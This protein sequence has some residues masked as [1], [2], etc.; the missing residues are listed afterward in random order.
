M[1][2]YASFEALI[3]QLMS[4]D[5][6]SRS[7]AES[8]FGELEKQPDALVHELLT[9]LINPS[10]NASCRPECAILLRR[11][12]VKKEPPLWDSVSPPAQATVKEKLL[13]LFS[14]EDNGS[15]HRKICDVVSD[16]AIHVVYKQENGWPELL[17]FMFNCVQSG[18]PR[19]MEGSLNMFAQIAPYM[20]PVLAQHLQTMYTI[21][22]T[23][24][25]E[26]YPLDVRTA[27]LAAAGVFMEELES[28][29]HR[30]QFFTLIPAMLEAVKAAVQQGEEKNAQEAIETFIEIAEVHPKFV[31]NCLAQVL[32]TMMAIAEAEGL[33]EATRKLACE[34]VVTLCEAREQAP[35]MM[36]KLPQ[37][38]HR[39]FMCLMNYLLDVE[40]DAEWYVSEEED[41]N[42]G[43]G[44]LCEFGQECLDR[45][46]IA[47]GGTAILHNAQGAAVVHA[48]LNNYPQ[49]WRY[50][51][52][53]LICLA[54][55]AEGCS[56]VML[57][58]IKG[59]VDTC[60]QGIQDPHPRVR[61]AACQ[62]IGQ[63]C[64]DLG[65]DIQQQEH[66]RILPALMLVM[67]D[68]ANP[69]V[70]GHASA[71]VV[72]F[73]DNCDR[74]L[75]AQYLDPLISSLISQLHHSTKAVKESALP[76]LSSLAD[77]AQQYFVKYYAEVMPLLFD[78]MIH[79]KDRSMLRAKCLECISLVG[80][81]VGRDQSREDAKRM[82]AMIT[83][84]QQDTDDPTFSYTL[85]AGARLCKCLGEE[86]LPYMDAVMPPLIKA[87]SEENYFEV[88]NE[89]EEDEENDDV[90]TFQLGDKSLQIRISALEEKAT[91][92][93]M[94]RCYADELKE[95]F[96]RWVE[97][98]AKMMVPMLKFFCWEDVRMAAVNS[99][100]PLLRSARLAAEK[101]VPG[102]SPE[103]CAHMLTY[104]WTHLMAA[105]Q[106]EHEP[107][108]MDC[109]VES[110]KEIV[111][112]LPEMMSDEQRN[113]AFQALEHVMTQCAER[114]MERM[115]RQ[116]N[117]DFDEEEAEALKEENELEEELTQQVANA[118]GAMLKQYG[119]KVMPLVEGLLVRFYP[120]LDK[121]KSNPEER[122]IAIGV[123][124]D[125]L[126]YAPTSSGKYLQ[127][128]MPIFLDAM[129]EPEAPDL[130]QC[131][132]YGIG[133]VAKNFT[134]EMAPALPQ[135]LEITLRM[136]QAPDA[137]SK[138]LEAR[139]DNAVSALG[140][141]MQV[142]S[143]QLGDQIP[144]LVELWLNALPLKEDTEE[145][146]SVHK[147]LVQ[148]VAAKHSAVLGDGNKNLQKVLEVYVRVLGRGTDLVDSEV[149]QAMV[150]QMKEIAAVLPPELPQTIASQLPAADQA[151]LQAFMAGQALS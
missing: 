129:V 47:L 140:C 84:W 92:C 85:Q 22:Q 82:M 19:L 104:L 114:R 107:T 89:D 15:L 21:L 81:A 37:L 55:I 146:K 137:R 50:R 17:P 60:L 87:A 102:A 52:A 38:N 88:T 49:D 76:A 80:M 8:Y 120:M 147:Q 127:Q 122:R 62:A 64:T 111:E 138:D 30:D 66:S 94:L 145:A 42:Q 139:F 34:F 24:M 25:A 130:N 18:N 59:L 61:W 12:L 96:F 32:D 101:Q 39:L 51:H 46:A 150:T 56:K 97:D 11:V 75:I 90:A 86:F 31:R 48:F 113:Q 7:A 43:E 27:A 69:R 10:A 40:D 41:A 125:M 148:M 108:V 121:S 29:Q 2:A 78:I 106:K 112:L 99:L 91:A 35:G 151:N 136:I 9:I 119:D 45:V 103:F 71:A 105:I 77:C 98:V 142:Y 141:L 131:A 93:N 110:I 123:M 63:M 128:M 36:R 44:E 57:K 83:Q 58:E 95:G 135:V 53:A 117:E 14:K 28:E 65:P 115:K 74:E 133:V 4:P 72:N 118:I 79:A 16:L 144:R 13:D 132:V 67:K 134:A 100:E 143:E 68:A 5:N 109:M 3:E 73:T 126:E 20:Q 116:E 54:Q 26:T 1:A 23:C 124:D 33:E 6:A 149:A 70:Q